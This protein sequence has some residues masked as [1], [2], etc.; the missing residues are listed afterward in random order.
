MSTN[1][2]QSFPITSDR[3]EQRQNTQPHR[4]YNLVLFIDQVCCL[5]LF[6]GLTRLESAIDHILSGEIYFSLVKVSSLQDLLSSEILSLLEKTGI[7]KYNLF[8]Y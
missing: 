8:N 4:T 5:V 1:V 3:P 2:Y 6:F 7:R